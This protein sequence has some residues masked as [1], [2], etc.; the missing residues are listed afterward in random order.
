[1]DQ[2]NSPLTVRHA[3]A[4]LPERVFDAWLDPAVAS[5]WLFATPDGQNVRCDID[6]RPGGAFVITDRRAGDDVEHQGAYLEIDRPRRLVFTFS[7]P[8]YS[9]TVTRVEVDLVKTATGCDVT[10]VH[11]GVLPEWA[12]QTEQGWHDLL[13]RLE[14]L[15]R[16]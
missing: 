11:H 3:F 10:L 15:L 6:P 8:K 9:S 7:V 12:S 14:E 5:R 1:M 2:P 4:S 16:G 13:Y